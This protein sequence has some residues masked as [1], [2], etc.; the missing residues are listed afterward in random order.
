MIFLNH[1][2]RGVFCNANLSNLENVF[3]R[4][5]R[6]DGAGECTFRASGGQFFPSAPNMVVPSWPSIQVLVCKKKSGYDTATRTLSKHIVAY[7]E[8]CVTLAYWEPRHIQNFTIF[9]IW[10]Y[11]GPMAYSESCLFGHI[12]VYS[13]MRKTRTTY[14]RFSPY[15][16][17]K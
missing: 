17:F 9:R 7:P 15:A 5:L 12:Q 6:T 3:S 1:P 10:T 14:Y 4:N 16:F 13:I 2:Q 11:L 8:R